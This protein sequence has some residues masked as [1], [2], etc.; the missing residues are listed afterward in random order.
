MMKNEDGKRM[1]LNY[2]W[3]HG[4]LFPLMENAGREVSEFINKKYGSK[5]NILVICGSGNNG[6]DGLV[7]ARSLSSGNNVKAILM[8]KKDGSISTLSRRAL[9]AFGEGKIIKNPPLER[10]RSLISESELVVD[11][12]FGTGIRDPVEEP[13][14]SII[15]EINRS[16]AVKISIDVPS[17]LGTSC[18][19]LPDATVTFTGKKDGMDSKNSG[20]ISIKK[21]GIGEKEINFAGPGEMVFFPK[22]ERDGHKGQNGKLLILAGWEYSGAGCMSARAAESSLS[23]LITIL[24]PRSKAMIFSVKLEDQIVG[25]YTSGNLKKQLEKCTAVLAGPGMGVSEDSTKAVISICKS[26]KNALFDADAIHIMAEN[27][28]MINKNMI[29]TP[30]SGEFK[31]LAGAEANR[32]NAEKF[33]RKY[34]CTVLLKGPTDIITDGKR[35]LLSEGGS[36]RMAMGGTGD[37]LA[38]LSAGLMARNMDPFRAAALGS[39]INKK[40]GEETEKKSSYWFNTY[41]LLENM[42]KTFRK[43]YEFRES[44]D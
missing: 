25:T 2:K 32:E 38:G 41:D 15:N 29:F 39:F 37:I 14:K 34:G 31:I 23:D 12:I 4:D 42:G 20:E 13:Y 9:E 33:C 22:V 44:S 10:I 8:T 30:H 21:I 27:R 28:E 6:G 36:P 3:N 1:D 35:T 24:V 7:A 16:K 5:K 26:G 11:G 19:V 40:N 18:G 17:G 43:Y